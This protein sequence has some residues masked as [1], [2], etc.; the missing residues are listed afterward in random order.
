[1]CLTDLP[2]MLLTTLVFKLLILAE[3]SLKLQEIIHIKDNIFI[4]QGEAFLSEP[5]FSLAGPSNL[6]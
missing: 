6:V 5:T 1:M 4:L 3:F 2:H